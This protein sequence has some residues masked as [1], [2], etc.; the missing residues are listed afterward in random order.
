MYKSTDMVELYNTYNNYLFQRFVNLV[1][2]A[3]NLCELQPKSGEIKYPNIQSH[4]EIFALEVKKTIESRQIITTHFCGFTFNQIF[5]AFRIEI[6]TCNVDLFLAV[7]DHLRAPFI[8][9]IA[10]DQLLMKFNRDVGKPSMKKLHQNFTKRRWLECD[11]EGS[12]KLFTH[13]P[14]VFNVSRYPV[15]RPLTQ[16]KRTSDIYQTDYLHLL[17]SSYRSY[18]LLYQV[19]VITRLNETSTLKSAATTTAG[20]ETIG[21]AATDARPTVASTGADAAADGTEAETADCGMS[22]AEYEEHT[23][24]VNKQRQDK[25]NFV[26]MEK[27]VKRL[28]R[29][30]EQSAVLDLAYYPRI[31]CSMNDIVVDSPIVMRYREDIKHYCMLRELIEEYASEYGTIFGPWLRAVRRRPVMPSLPAPEPDE[32]EGDGVSR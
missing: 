31:D 24:T 8:Q 26:E 2:H 28:E 20:G 22:A 16:K 11:E 21:T 3:I 12:R 14:D 4:T 25:F 29:L 32:L 27:G 15:Y 13:V 19:D 9:I 1:S 23:R 5:S 7:I 10:I 30:A 6:Q 18:Q 17:L